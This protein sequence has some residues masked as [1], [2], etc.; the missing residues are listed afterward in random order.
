MNAALLALTLTLPLYIAA[1]QRE[2]GLD[3]STARVS[4][5]RP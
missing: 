5:N 2:R 4:V 1:L 3:F